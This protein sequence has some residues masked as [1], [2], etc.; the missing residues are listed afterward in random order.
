MKKRFLFLSIALFS[1]VSNAQ[2]TRDLT[3]VDKLNALIFH[4]QRSY[5]DEVDTDKLVD[6]AI[7][8]MLEELDPH[9]MYITKEDLQ[10]MNEP[11]EGNFEGI[12][13]QFN[14]IRDTILVVSPIA[15]G[16]SEKL[17]ILS[18]D[19]IVEI[20]GEVVAGVG[21]KNQDVMRMLKGPKDTKVN[22]S[23][24][25]KGVR[26]LIPFEITRDK[27]P[28]YSVDAHYMAEPG[29]GYIKVNRFA[30]TTMS[31]FREALSNLNEQGM[32]DLILDLQGNGGGLLR[33]AVEMADEFIDEQKLIVYTEG[34]AYPRRDTRARVNG[35]FEQGRLVVLIDE[36]SASASE[37]VSGAVQ[38]WDRGLIIGRRSFGKGL[39]QRPV[40]LPDSSAVRLTVQ[41]YYTP[42]GRSIQKPYDDGVENYKK[43]RYERFFNGELTNADSIQLPDSLRFFTARKRLVYGGGG[44]MPDIFVAL[45]T[46]QFSDYNTALIRK[47][48]FNQ[49]SLDYTE[50]NRKTLKSNYST[51]DEFIAGFECTDEMMQRFF[52]RGEKEGV[53]FDQEGYKQSETLIKQRLK[54]LIARNLWDTSAYYQVF[55]PS[56]PVYQRAID[57]LNSKEYDTMNLASY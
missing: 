12:G 13:V 14:I 47:G 38:D 24:K 18:G 44:I 10:A 32:K 6:A 36:G 49:F 31:E 1:I 33:A 53:D 57:A 2:T 8:A 55:N 34:R 29:V 17:G 15:G 22:V 21:I 45:D 40:E 51:V 20:E 30:A 25:R 19:R 48:V 46:S 7:V 11:L 3:P 27:I 50:Q 5:V 41:R 56:W 37:I 23:I 39:V 42:S 16:P 54:A 26:N 28:I 52:D 9:S 4:I 35:L 43:E